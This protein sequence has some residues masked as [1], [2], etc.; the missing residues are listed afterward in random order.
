MRRCTALHEYGTRYG[1]CDSVSPA[2]ARFLANSA[3]LEVFFA[4][5]LALLLA[6]A[7]IHCEMSL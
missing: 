1:A 7:P 6:L 2:V 5:F 4:L 3:G